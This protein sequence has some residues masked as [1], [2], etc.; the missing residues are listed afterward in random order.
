MTLSQPTLYVGVAVASGDANLL[1]TGVFDTVLV[2]VPAANQP[3]VVSLSAPANGATFTAPA[4]ITVSATASDADGAVTA[5][6]FYAGQTLIGSDPTSPYSVTWNNVPAGMY[7]LTAVARDD[8]SATTTSAAR[9]ITVTSSNQ[10]PTV[11]LTAPANGATFT[12]PAT[13]TVSATASDPDGTVTTV[14][15]YADQTLIGSDPTSPYSVTWSSVPAGSYQLTAVA[16]DED[17]GMTVSASRAV[18]VNDPQMPGRALFTASG[19]H[20]SAVDY[21]VVEIFPEGADPNGANAIAAQNIGK[22]PV[23]N[24][25]CEADVRNMIQ[26]LT[27]GSYIAT[28]TA[29]GSAGSARS[30]PAPFTR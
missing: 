24:G 7:S 6:D 2:S 11:S 29:F 25:E 16:R 26:S 13:I 18:T 20:D 23:V 4:T 27:P 5:V 3:P 9:S 30:A 22:P 21:Y 10:V 19:N 17:G 1:A 8:D 15:F 12:A 28:V 14:E